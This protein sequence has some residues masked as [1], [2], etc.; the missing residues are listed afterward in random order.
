[1][2]LHATIVFDFSGEANTFFVGN[3]LTTLRYHLLVF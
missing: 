1:M 3:I 2:C